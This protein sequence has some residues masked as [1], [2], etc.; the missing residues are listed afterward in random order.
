MQDS[1]I[2]GTGNSRYLKSVANFLELYPDYISFATALIA[3]T[4]P[5]DLA[6]INDAGWQQIGHALNKETLLDDNTC[7]VMGL[8][9]TSVPND[10]FMQLVL[11]DGK[12]AVKV[13]VLTPG[14]RPMPDVTISNL[15]LLNGETAV[16]NVNGTVIGFT[17]SQTITLSPTHNYYDIEA[18]T[19]QTVTLSAGVL[20]NVTFTGTR[21]A[22]T[23]KT[24]SAS[25]TVRFSADVDSFDCSAIGGGENGEAGNAYYSKMTGGAGGNA[26]AIANK[27][28]IPNTSQTIA[29]TVGAANG[30]TSK[31]GSYITASGGAGASGGRGAIIT[32]TTKT[33]TSTAGRN[34]SGFLYPPTDVGGAGGGGG[35]A[36][37]EISPHTSLSASSGGSPGGGA[38]GN[39]SNSKGYDGSLPGAGGGGGWACYN[40]DSDGHDISTNGL[41]GA[42]QPGLCGLV[43]RYKS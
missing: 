38:G 22:D 13:T 5:V 33:R 41:A 19:P 1:I 7:D 12:Y 25:T 27:S 3:G 8:P 43:W 34:S 36:N 32:G 26:G 23:S 10:A 20:N 16:T 30:G 40:E 18:L 15:T 39:I 11:P 17:T 2:L 4:L 24:F 35:A 31:V 29:I 42:G 28:N 37:R 21:I 9:H 14:G 6:G